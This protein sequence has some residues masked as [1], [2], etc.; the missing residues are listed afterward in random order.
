MLKSFRLSKRSRLGL[1]EVI[2]AIL[3]LIIVLA[4]G[5]AFILFSMQQMSTQ[6][7]S[8]ADILKRARENQNQLLS[9]V[10]FYF[11]GSKVHLYVYNYG[12]M[13][14]TVEKAYSIVDETAEEVAITP[15]TFP[16][17]TLI[18]ATFNFT[19]EQPPSELVILSTTGA[20]FSIKFTGAPMEGFR[21][22]L[23]PATVQLKV[24]ESQLFTCSV[25][26]GQPPYV[27]QWFER[28]G[29]LTQ[30]LPETGNTYLFNATESGIFYLW[31]TVTDNA[32]E[33]TTSNIARISVQLGEEQPGFEIVGQTDAL[34][35]GNARAIVQANG[36]TYLFYKSPVTNYLV[37]QVFNGSQWSQNE[38]QASH[39][40]ITNGEAFTILADNSKVYIAYSIGTYSSSLTSTVYLRVGTISASGLLQLSDAIPLLTSRGYWSFDFART[41]SKVFFALRHC[42]GY[43]AG[44]Y[45]WETRVFSSTDGITWTQI[46]S[47]G[48]TGYTWVK[49]GVAIAKHPLFSDGVVLFYWK[50]SFYYKEYN[51]SDWLHEKK[52][53]VNL[54]EGLFSV[55]FGGEKVYL[56]YTFGSSLYYKTFNG[57]SWSDQIQLDA[58]SILCPML[59]ATSEK[60]YLF[61]IKEDSVLYLS[62]HYATGQVSDV[63]EVGQNVVSGQINAPK[64]FL[65]Q[66]YPI[67][68]LSGDSAPYD[69]VVAYV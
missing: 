18:E 24:G 49:Y 10:Y 57:T 54:I 7:S 23:F 15:E 42:V 21:A 53:G 28:V 17:Q 22:T 48:G 37:Y 65:T 3:I 58:G 9:L 60:M 56:T 1:S 59:S 55:S 31:V 4:V 35:K 14:I 46:F 43:F 12:T 34:P 26:G 16:A 47:S 6:A 5:I 32:G 51:G 33:E 39:T 64:R 69:L 63:V 40:T 11:E 61:Y 8:I 27:Y 2:G 25:F 66:P 30:E 13:N 38:Y 52:L 19:T 41:D 68:W 45:K 62:L 44:I 67:I 20:A 50:N 29:S 36:F